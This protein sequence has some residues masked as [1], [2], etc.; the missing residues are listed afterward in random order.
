MRRSLKCRI[1]ITPDARHEALLHCYYYYDH[2][3]IIYLS[4][5]LRTSFKTMKT[6]VNTD[7]EM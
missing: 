5:D 2:I 1:V 3:V 6:H 4:N 7:Q